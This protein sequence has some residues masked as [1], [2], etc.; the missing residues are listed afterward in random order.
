[1]LA[2]LGTG[3]REAPAVYLDVQGMLPSQG[4]PYPCPGPSDLPLLGTQHCECPKSRLRPEQDGKQPP[5]SV[6][7]VPGYPFHSVPLIRR[8]DG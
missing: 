1:M 2:M 6:S 8:S 7:R 3:S 4:N 5:L